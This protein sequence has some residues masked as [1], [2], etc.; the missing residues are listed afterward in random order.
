MVD[1]SLKLLFKPSMFNY[2]YENEDGELVIYN[3]YLGLQK[4]IKFKN[5]KQLVK[6]ILTNKVISEDIFDK[7]EFFIAKGLY[8]RGFLVEKEKNEKNLRFIKN[9]TRKANNSLLFV[10]HTTKNCNFRCKYCALDFCRDNLHKSSELGIINYIEKNIKNYNSISFSW[11]GGE[12][13]LNM[14]SIEFLSKKVIEICNLYK[15][16]YRSSITTNG[17]LL[18]PNI[19][20][21]LINYKVFRIVITIDGIKNTHDSLRV[22]ADGSPTF[23]KIINNL[24]FLRDNVKDRRLRI[25][26][27]T[28][29]TKKSF[30]KIDEYYSFFDKEFGHDKRFSLFARIAGDWGGE[31]VKEIS[32]NLLDN[33]SYNFILKK[34]S[35]LKGN[36]K[37]LLNCEDI[38]MGGYCNANYLNKFTIGV[39]GLISKCDSSD[40][41]ISIGKLNENGLMDIDFDEYSKWLNNLKYVDEK[42]DN[43]FYSINCN[44]CSCPKIIAK[45]KRKSCVLEDLDLKELINL[46]DK[47]YGI[48]FVDNQFNMDGVKDEKIRN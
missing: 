9:F 8:E 39:D 19:I 17:Y 11:F 30:E 21:E 22:L 43:C 14:K 28:N 38:D 44:F 6:K 10:I 4:S 46:Y 7:E 35:N 20:N 12:P 41:E 26:I 1:S 40:K 33:N 32:S 47:S 15:I 48:N 34:I 3:S 27:R 42:C 37:F 18:S 13:L 29:F 31:R 5:H 45:Y 2:F 23:D 36:I 16:P 25:I 24:K